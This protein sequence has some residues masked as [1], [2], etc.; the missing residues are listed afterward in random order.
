MEKSKK[1][2]N[3]KK[4][5]SKKFN[6]NT[7]NKNIKSNKKSLKKSSPSWKKTR[8]NYNKNQNDELDFN[9][10]VIS[11][12]SN[13]N[14]N[15]FIN[16]KGF[17]FITLLFAFILVCLIIRIG[18]IQFVEGSEL[19]KQAYNQQTINQ[20]ISPDRGNIYDSTGK[21]LAISAQVDTITINP[22]KIVKKTDDE[23]KF[24]KEFV[25][26]GLSDIFELNYD[27]VLA[28]V[29]STEQVETIIKKVEQDKVDE[30][31]KW[32]DDNNI[33]VGINID[34][35]IKRYYPYSN[36]LS[37]VIGFCGTDNSGL[38]GLEYTWNNILTGT[39]GKIV[40]SQGSDQREIPNST[41]TYISAENGS[42]LELTVDLNIQT[43]VE[44]YLQQAVDNYDCTDGGNIIIMAPETGDIL[45]M[46]SY[47]DYNLN[48]PYTP[49]SDLGQTYADES[50]YKM[51]ANKSVSDT[52]EPGSTFKI[53][54]SAIALEENITTPDV[55]GDFYCNGYEEFPDVNNSTIRIKCWRAEPHGEQS[56]RD[57][58]ANSCNPS[59]MQL[60][61][62]IT[63]PTL[64]K[65][66]NAFGLFDVTNS[67]LYGEQNSIFLSPDKVGPVD[68]AT[69]SFGQGL[70]ITPLQMTTALSAI[71]NDGLLMQPRI[72][73]SVTNS[74]TGVKTDID[75]ISVRQVVSK[76][77]SE[78]ILSMM[79]TVVSVGTGINATVEG[80]TIGGKTG[81]SENLLGTQENDYIASFTATAPAHDPELVIL[82]TL[83]N[84]TNEQYGFQGGQIA[85]PVVSQILSEIL[86]YMGVTANN[87]SEY[88]NP[89]N[90]ITVPELRNK[91]I[92]EAERILN[93]LNLNSTIFS[94]TD[95]NT[96]LVVEQNPKPGSQ[97]SKDSL[98]ILYGEGD[99]VST[100][101]TIP[102]LT[103]MNLSQA[104]NTLK[105]LNLNINV[106]GSGIVTN[107][108]YLK[109]EQVPIG[110]IVNVTF[111]PALS[112]AQ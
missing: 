20:I 52:Y 61:E 45:A 25:A 48:T 51:W 42:D 76:E 91:T 71:A 43:V 86:P 111:K 72:V 44:K 6:K 69:I 63:T 36:V 66:Y 105:N 94:T 99:N 65:Y 88:T 30:L 55:P 109:G 3:K 46:A 58:L 98:V 40:S 49:I 92:A 26:K 8:R 54:T 15:N 38:A 33:S 29:Q 83:Y 1:N 85:A 97:L 17:L 106:E 22:S 4:Q 95:K 93:D 84:P 78:E 35:D 100:S 62:R 24:Y 110:T 74:D 21:A 56:L 102:D 2:L 14:P 75:P 12:N 32:M 41:E 96:T 13:L 5:T 90:L 79:E 64:Y 68:L 112:G 18:Y 101:V 108:E 47:P 70:N 59:F 39:P 60:G 10:N 23:T 107:Q 31:T 81:T 80:Y 34:D 37:S 73:K 11:L 28:K 16:K 67:T 19:Q 53:I 9:K 87:T 82:V 57:A 103:G 89:E 27:E 77:T 50:I 7:V 104:S